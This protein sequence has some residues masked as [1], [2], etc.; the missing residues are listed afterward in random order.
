M[1][2]NVQVCI[3]NDFV[4]EVFIAETL[5][6]K[7]SVTLIEVETF[8]IYSRV[9]VVAK[10]GISNV[11]QDGVNL[12]SIKTIVQVTVKK[13]RTNILKTIRVVHIENDLNIRVLVLVL[14]TFKLD[15]RIIKVVDKIFR[16]ETDIGNIAKD[17]V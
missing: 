2:C 3:K 12:Q 4:I 16:R 8:P 14:K 13:V 6:I 10:V 15:S 7:V 9:G 1:R 11:V 5:N 17:F